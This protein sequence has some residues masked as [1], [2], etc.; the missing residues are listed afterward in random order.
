[1][2]EPAASTLQVKLLFAASSPFF[3]DHFPGDPLVPAFVQLAEVRKAAL[4]WKGLSTARIKVGK[5]KFL[6]P[7]SPDQEYHLILKQSEG[8]QSITFQISSPEQEI[9]QGELRIE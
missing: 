9:T 1:M 3:D 8:Q 2:R 5:V 4:A 7:M 6:R